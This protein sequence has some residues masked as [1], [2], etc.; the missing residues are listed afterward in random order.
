[1]KNFMKISALSS[2]IALAFLAVSCGP[3]SAPVSETDL[4]KY[5]LKG[6]VA[7]V[8]STSYK[9]D[10]IAK[11]PYKVAE[12]E[13]SSNNVYVE[14]NDFG[15]ATRLER[16]NRAG[17]VVS[18]Q[19]SEYNENGQITRSCITNPEGDVM[20]TT[21]YKYKRGRLAEMTTTDAQDS[22]KKHEVYKY[23]DRDSVVATFSYKEDKTAGR[24]VSK[25]DENGY[26]YA[27]VTYSNKDKVL[28]EFLMEHDEAG[29]N[30]AINSEN[31][32][33]GKLDSEMK[34]N[35]DGFRSEMLMKGKSAETVFRFE[36]ELDA[37]GNWTKKITYK[38]DAER[39]I[40]IE[41]RK[42]EYR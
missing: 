7:S 24:R 39:P 31:V 15:M 27:T 42:I 8:R 30:I 2:A 6:P 21:V 35:E 14:F 36:Y 32:F 38:D 12:V 29:R 41:M 18:I 3:K 33:F 37:N 17:K 10:S 34:Y 13:V 23:Y 25:Y 1:M 22:L 5:E 9:V 20:E 19:E 16:F 40:R 11:K 26:N 28:S 4:E